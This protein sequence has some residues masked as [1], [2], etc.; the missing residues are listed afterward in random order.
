[1]TGFA[2]FERTTQQE[3]T[4]T[5]FI[6]STLGLFLLAVVGIVLFFRVLE[7]MAALLASLALF[8]VV[9]VIAV[10]LAPSLIKLD[11]F[12]PQILAAAKQATG[13]EIAIG[14]PIGFSVWPVL[15]LQL[16]DISIGNKEG[17]SPP[18]MASASELGVGITLPSLFSGKLEVNELRLVDA[19]LNLSTN[20]SGQGNW[21]L[22]PTKAKDVPQESSSDSSNATSPNMLQDIQLETITIQNANLVFE[23]YGGTALEVEKINLAL[24]MPSLDG[25]AE[26]KASA[27]VK[28]QTYSASGTLTSPRQLMLG[29]T[30]KTKLQATL[31]K[32]MDVAYDGTLSMSNL[33]GSLTAVAMGQKVSGNVEAGFKET[34]I[35]LKADLQTDVVDLDKLMA[36]TPTTTA[37]SASTTTSS[38]SNVAPSA[39]PAKA[40]QP[41]LSAL[42][43][44]NADI[45][46]Q[47]AGLKVKG[48]DIGATTA[49]T[50]IKGGMLTANITPASFSS[51]TIAG[52][53]TAT[54]SNRFTFN[55]EG[56]GVEIGPILE[57][58][59]DNDRLTGKGD[60]TLAFNGPIADT[61]TLKAGLN[62]NGQFALRDGALKGVNLAALVRK[63]KATLS[64]GVAGDDGP[65]QTDFTE[66]T[67]SFT[68]SNGVISNQDL[69]MLSPLVRVGGKGTVSLPADQINYRLETVLVADTTGQGGTADKKGLVIPILVTGPLTKPTYAPDLQGLVLGNLGSDPKATIQSLGDSVKELKG[70][71]KKDD[72]KKGA[73]GML[74]GLLGGSGQ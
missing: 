42:N 13:R 71:I 22:K 55:A 58:M 63:A 12:K 51:G 9:L 46:L 68:A 49:K 40:G 19:Q 41:D 24:A 3:I 52:K 17:V 2:L 11:D 65:Q 8:V 45:A 37:T 31:G 26:F 70:D 69:K 14:G 44:L 74:K 60:I 23:P 62:G 18:V 67:G 38:S 20:K 5:G 73:E 7:K 29:E 34:P 25:S 61:P 43:Q 48:M 39:K 1:M 15:G 72:L 64:G 32:D 28:S 35:R 6:V 50:T 4:M 53:A 16:K 56:K 36:A 59:A 10:I 47:I 27:A 66:L 30:A 54:A 21:V 57:K 33:K